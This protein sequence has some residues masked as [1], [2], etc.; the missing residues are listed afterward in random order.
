MPTVAR[1]R[2]G[3]SDF[4]LQPRRDRLKTHTR[5]VRRYDHVDQRV[6]NLATARLFYLALLPALGFTRDDSNERWLEFESED[7]EVSDYFA[8]T[9]SSDHVPGQSRIAFWAESPSEVDR[10]AE[11]VMQGGG[12]NIEGPGYEAPHYY[13]VFFEDPDGNRFEICHR[14]S[15]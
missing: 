11:I 12:C 8:V 2:S 13:A 15:N 6:R 10:L 7:G 1:R 9:E 4:G 5:T 14:T 3:A